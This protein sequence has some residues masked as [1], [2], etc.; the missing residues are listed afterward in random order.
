MQLYYSQTSPFARKV[1]I[2]L[3]LSQLIDQCELIST[4]FTSDALRSKNPLGKIPA[5][6]DGDLNLFDSS[7]ICDY[8]DDK[9]IQSSQVSLFKKNTDAYFNVQK[10]HYLANGILDAAVATVMENKRETECS[11]LW[12]GRWNEAMVSAITYIDTSQLGDKNTLH[13]GS[14]TT[15]SALGYLNFRL[16]NFEWQKQNPDLNNWFELL[17]NEP[18]F[19]ET[20]PE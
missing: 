15:L 10:T 16:P 18:F 13:I 19:I 5:L 6:V 1:R 20:A 7:L 2:F 14:I 3:R 12:L 9:L 4:S 11:P 17:K 8:L